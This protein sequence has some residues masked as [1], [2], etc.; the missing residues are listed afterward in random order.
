MQQLINFSADDIMHDKDKSYIK[1]MNAIPGFKKVVAN[2]VGIIGEKYASV[3]YTGNG[4][5]INSKSYPN[6]FLSFLESKRILGIS[7]DLAISTD[8]N[9]MI[10]SFTVGDKNK[11]VILSTGSIDLLNRD[12]LQ[13]VIGHELGHIKCNHIIYQ[14]LTE[15]IFM[16]MQDSTL[17]ALMSVIKF[18]LLDWYR[19]SD[20]T[21][22]RAGLLCCQD[23]N[24]AL[25][26][27]IKMSGLPKSQYHNIDIAAFIKQAQ[28]FSKESD[29]ID[30]AIKYL[31]INS[32]F[33][34]W[35]VARAASL[36]EW[37]E[38]GAYNSILHKSKLQIK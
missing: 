15:S 27:M 34:P 14:M 36:L 31:S 18:T 17:K 5:N 22:D 8:W 6:L 1:K 7:E 37:Y 24:T 26:V 16:P 4:V 25:R 10:N 32:A 30:K 20:F 23:I 12:E 11:R 35:T 2:T 33:H 9:Y 3:E 38:S 19:I 29:F 13:F 28:E 21:A